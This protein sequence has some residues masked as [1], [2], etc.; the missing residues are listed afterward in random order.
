MLCEIKAQASIS[1]AKV[2]IGGVNIITK[3]PYIGLGHTQKTPQ[4]G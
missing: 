2:Q 4:T 3:H 1:V